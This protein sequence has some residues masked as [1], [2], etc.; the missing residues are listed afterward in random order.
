ML[1]ISDQPILHLC[2]YKLIKPQS[3]AQQHEQI[4]I[5]SAGW[6]SGKLSPDVS[7]EVFPAS[8]DL[9][10]WGGHKCPYSVITL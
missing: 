5:S 3:T 9:V 6:R 8:G 10:G 4:N 7:D 2:D 1:L